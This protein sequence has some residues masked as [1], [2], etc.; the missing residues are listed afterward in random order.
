MYLLFIKILGHF[1]KADSVHTLNA[2]NMQMK[3]T[4]DDD[5]MPQQY[6]RRLK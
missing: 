5:E 2:L 4:E 3:Q 6:P 1:I